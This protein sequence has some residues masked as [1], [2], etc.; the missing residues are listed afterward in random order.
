MNMQTDIKNGDVFEVELEAWTDQGET[1]SHINGLR[2]VVFGGIPGERVRVEVLRVKKEYLAAKFVET[3]SASK[4]RQ[5]IDCP[6]F[7]ECT[8]CQ[9]RHVT[10][11]TQL[12]VKKRYLEEILSRNLSLHNGIVKDVVPSPAQNHYRNHARFTINK[13]GMLGFIGK[14]TRRFVHITKCL[15]M[16]DHINNL[17]GTLQGKAAQTRQLSIRASEFSEGHLIQP[18]LKEVAIDVDTGQPFYYEHINANRFK[19]AS[20]SFFQDNND[21]VSNIIEA[22]LGSDMIDENSRVLDAYAGV[23]TLAI[24]IAP[25]VKYVLG[26]EDSA[27]AVA[28]ANENSDGLANVSFEVGK[29]EDLIFSKDF[30]FDVAILDPSR[31]GCAPDALQGLLERTPEKIIYISCEPKTL[32]RDL[33]VLNTKYEIMEVIPFDMFPHTYHLESMTFLRLRNG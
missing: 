16:S 8:G 32:S 30:D 15:L 9:Y 6:Y 10:Y 1:L 11:T 29:T 4:D 19:V 31:K 21:Q 13:E 27:A 23:G 26:I 28:D 5:L 22:I 24:L 12:E 17:M 14:E 18:K 7:G 2:T 3:L 25:Y 20:P 33:A